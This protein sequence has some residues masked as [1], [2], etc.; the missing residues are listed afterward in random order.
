MTNNPNRNAVSDLLDIK[1]LFAK[2]GIDKLPPEKQDEIE[3][4][5]CDL[6]QKRVSLRLLDSMTEDQKTRAE[7]MTDDD[8][9]DFFEREGIDFGAAMVTEAAEFGGELIE[10]LSYIKGLIDGNRG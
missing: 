3:N 9:Y 4:K 2:Y 6:F 7:N 5:I 10:Y 8:L 1:A